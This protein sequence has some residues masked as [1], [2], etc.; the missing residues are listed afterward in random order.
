MPDFETRWQAFKEAHQTPEERAKAARRL[1]G[2]QSQRPLLLPLRE[3][4]MRQVRQG[5]RSPAALTEEELQH[6]DFE[7]THGRA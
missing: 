5:I 3:G 1:T 2:G 7:D 6:L 4:T